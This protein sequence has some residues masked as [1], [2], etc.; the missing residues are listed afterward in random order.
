ML[1]LAE[2]RDAAIQKAGDARKIA[3]FIEELAGR[4]CWQRI[5][6]RI[7]RTQGRKR[8]A[9]ERRTMRRNCPQTW[10]KDARA[11]PEGDASVVLPLLLPRLDG[12][13]VRL[14]V[15]GTELMAEQPVAGDQLEGAAE[16]DERP[17]GVAGGETAGGAAQQAAR[18]RDG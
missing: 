1:S 16:A 17:F 14:E 18:L 13:V 8:P 12:R 2:V 5:G 15:L 3:K 4:D 7:W 9:G 10:K 11:W 6:D